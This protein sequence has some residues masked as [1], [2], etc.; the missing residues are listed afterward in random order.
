M[1]GTEWS[2]LDAIGHLA[3]PAGGFGYH[4]NT[5]RMVDEEDVAFPPHPPPEELWI[6]QIEAVRRVI[7]D[8][9]EYVEGMS[10]ER[11]EKTPLRRSQPITVVGRLEVMADLVAEH[12]AQT[13]EQVKPRL[14]LRLSDR[15][16]QARFGVHGALPATKAATDS[17]ENRP[18]TSGCYL[19]IPL[20]PNGE[21]MWRASQA[22]PSYNKSR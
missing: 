3:P 13:R 11:L 8:T 16:S 12:T 1:R 22:Y 15:V 18:S 9:I 14:G 7:D 2:V 5:G 10:P 21:V 19:A 17:T 4:R 20:S 6:R